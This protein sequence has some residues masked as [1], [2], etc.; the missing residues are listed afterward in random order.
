MGALICKENLYNVAAI[1]VLF[2][3]QAC[4]T[5]SYDLRRR[6]VRDTNGTR[7][8]HKCNRNGTW[9]EHKRNIHGTRMEQE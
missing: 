3:F 7:M 4:S 5:Q 8:E 1:Y 9:I 2:M 6:L